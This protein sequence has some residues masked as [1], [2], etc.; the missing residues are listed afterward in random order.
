M[1]VK[2]GPKQEYVLHDSIEIKLQVGLKL[3]YTDKTR[4]MVRDESWLERGMREL[5]GGDGKFLYRN[6]GVS[7]TVVN[8]GQIVLNCIL[9]IC[10][11]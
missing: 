4:N 1:W 5:S 2:N 3:I 9:M 8:I 11:F 7:Y 6:E 10:V